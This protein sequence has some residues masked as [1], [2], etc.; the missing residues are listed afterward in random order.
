[1]T[2]TRAVITAASPTQPTLPLQRLVDRN[3]CEKTALELIIEEVLQAGI[4][5]MGLVICPGQQTAFAQ[6]AGDHT[7]RIVFIEQDHPRGYGDALLR[8]RDFV[9]EEPFLHLVSDHLYLSHHEQGCAQQL[10]QAA[11]SERCSVSGVQPTRESMLPYF[12]TVG[13]SP[14]PQRNDMYVI[15]Q[16]VEK[17]TPTIAE[18]ELHVAGLRAGYYLCFFGMHVLSPLIMELL[19][20]EADRSESEASINLSPALSRLA[21]QEKYLAV[22]VEGSRYNIGVRYGLLRAQLAIALSGRD[23]DEVLRDLVELL[24][25]RESH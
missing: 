3:G 20:E 13:G 18:Q 7:K 1:M 22:A 11:L 12:G 17:P 10:I 9:G 4:E 24:A 19:Q 5:T 23:R 16:V 15:S 21:T 6:A 25:T 8:A 14:V 2:I